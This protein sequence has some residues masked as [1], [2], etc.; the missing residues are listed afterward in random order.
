MTDPTP[1]ADD[2]LR[3]AVM[4]VR[5]EEFDRYIELQKQF[6]NQI[7]DDVLREQMECALARMESLNAC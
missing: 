2:R 7:E 1:T 6:I 3:E 4:I 5:R